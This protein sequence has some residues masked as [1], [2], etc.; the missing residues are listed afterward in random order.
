VSP[1][2]GETAYTRAPRSQVLEIKRPEAGP[3]RF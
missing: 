3:W 1:V 2:V